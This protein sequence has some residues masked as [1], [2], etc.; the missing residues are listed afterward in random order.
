[1]KVIKAPN[2]LVYEDEDGRSVFLA[3]SI[4][5]GAAELWQ[6]KVRVFGEGALCCV[7][8]SSG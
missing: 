1:M 4:E 2:R 7:Q 3:G 6:D 8:S 5:M